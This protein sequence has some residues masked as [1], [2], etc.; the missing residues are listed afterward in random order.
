MRKLRKEIH[1]TIKDVVALP[2]DFQ[3]CPGCLANYFRGVMQPH[4]GLLFCRRCWPRREAH[5]QVWKGKQNA[6]TI[7]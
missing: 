7:R 6:K 3:R 2:S 4:K 1:E 5:Y